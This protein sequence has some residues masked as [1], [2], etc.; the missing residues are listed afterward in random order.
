M[1]RPNGDDIRHGLERNQR[2]VR[3]RDTVVVQFDE[4]GSL[5]AIVESGDLAVVGHR[6]SIATIGDEGVV[7]CPHWRSAFRLS[8][9]F[10]YGATLQVP[11][12]PGPLLLQTK[13]VQ[14]R[15]A[16]PGV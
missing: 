5:D 14:Q 7:R 15:G 12:P 4:P 2:E 3:R 1:N 13:P 6:A 8:R 16:S 10:S 9:F 11:V